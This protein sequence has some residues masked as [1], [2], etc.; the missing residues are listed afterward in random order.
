MEFPA[1]CRHILAGAQARRTAMQESWYERHV[2]SHVLDLLCG[3]K[4][5]RR[6]RQQLMPLA[7]GKVLEI[8]IRTGLNIPY[9]DKAHVHTLIGIDPALRMHR[10]ARKSGL[11][12]WLMSVSAEALPLDAGSMDTAVMTY[13]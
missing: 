3:M 4:P 11:D 10:R 8:V 12:V 13:T 2:L 7:R 6:Q 1:E 9:Y 5:I